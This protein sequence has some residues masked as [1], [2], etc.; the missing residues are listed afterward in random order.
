M[1]L[2][3]NE[4]PKPRE[5]SPLMESKNMNDEREVIIPKDNSRLHFFCDALEIASDNPG[6][7]VK[8]LGTEKTITVEEVKL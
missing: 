1:I 2:G 8:I 6:K 4:E 5:S 7:K 3:E